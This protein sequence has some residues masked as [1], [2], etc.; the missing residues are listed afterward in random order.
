MDLSPLPNIFHPLQVGALPLR[1]RIVLAPLTRMRATKDFVPQLPVMKEYYSQRARTPG[2]LLISEGTFISP[3]GTGAWPNAPG[4]WSSAQ[5]EAWRE[6]TTAVHANGSF[7]FLQIF[8]T[9]R[10]ADSSY[11]AS[12]DLKVVAPSPIPLST[13]KIPPHVLSVEEI[14]NFTAEFVQAARNGIEAGFDGVEVHVANGFLLDQFLQDVSN[15]REDQYGGSVENRARFPLEVVSAVTQAIGE[16]RVSVRLSP[17]SPFSDMGMKDPVPTFS[18]FAGQLRER[19]PH[20]AYLHV[21]EPR[22]SGADDREASSSESNDFLREIW[23]GKPLVSAG[24]YNG[25]SG[26]AR[27]QEN[28]NELIAF[29][30]HFIANP[31]LPLRFCQGV[32]LQPYDRSTFYVPGDKSG[33]GYSDYGFATRPIVS[34]A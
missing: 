20:L 25:E 6:I 24:G 34:A 4:I 27:A 31:D 26:L 23:K 9:G 18:Y 12:P 5:I 19:C 21:I 3:A 1:H 15:T 29:G 11:L 22:I 16:E 17:W 10:S 33:K 8:A 32:S 28:G 2:T 7:I 13:Q 14:H 30:R